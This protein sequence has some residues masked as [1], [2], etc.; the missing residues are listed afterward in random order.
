MALSN[1]ARANHLGVFLPQTKNTVTSFTHSIETFCSFTSQISKTITILNI[2]MGNLNDY[3]SFSNK[4]I[5]KHKND[6]ITFY[7]LSKLNV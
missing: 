6:F 2:I 1:I 4:Y 5:H 3:A 7:K